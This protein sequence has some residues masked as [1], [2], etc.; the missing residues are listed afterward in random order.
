MCQTVRKMYE[1]LR[2]QFAFRE[3][4]S[5][6]VNISLICG[7]KNLPSHS[8]HIKGVA[9]PICISTLWK[10]K[11]LRGH[12]LA[13]KMI[14]SKNS[15]P[16]DRAPN[17]NPLS[18]SNVSSQLTRY[19]WICVWRTGTPIGSATQ[20][21]VCTRWRSVVA[22]LHKPKPPHKHFVLDSQT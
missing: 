11:T 6:T 7:R 1:M 9:L 10:L 4:A 2:L 21:Q 20:G 17:S 15:S 14:H 22:H 3:C 12:S 5:C 19:R 16:I 8:R 18:V 13:T